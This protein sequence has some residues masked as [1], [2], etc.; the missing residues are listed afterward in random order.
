MKK[1]KQSFVEV[2]EGNPSKQHYINVTV[3]LAVLSVIAGSFLTLAFVFL[4][5][6]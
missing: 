1:Y 4:K 3:A 5:V 2:I 6:K